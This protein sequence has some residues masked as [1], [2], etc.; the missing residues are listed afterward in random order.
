MNKKTKKSKAATKNSMGIHSIGVQLI[1]QLAVLLLFVCGILIF[2]SYSKSRG[3]IRQ[4]TEE[5]LQSRVKENAELLTDHLNEKKTQIETL[6]RR[7]SIFGM[8]WKE[9]EPVIV[10][11][12][13]RLGYERI[14]VSDANGD[15][16]LPG[17]DV[18]NI[19]DKQNFQISLKGDSYTTTPLFSESDQKLIM[20][21]TAAIRNN[22][23]E[24]VGVLGGVST[25]EDF[26]A[27]VQKIEAGKNG[28]A[29]L[30]DETGKRIAD[31]DIQKVQDGQNDVETYA[32]NAEYKKYIDV[33]KAMM[34]GKTGVSEYFYEGENYICAYTPVEGTTWSLAM[35]YQE[36]EALQDLQSLRNFMIG[37]MIFAMILG[38]VVAVFI[39]NRIRKPLLQMQKFAKELA[40]GNLGYQIKITRKDEFGETCEHLN[41]AAENMKDSMLIIVDNAS[42]VSAS[43]EELYAT[44]EEITS[45]IEEID[46][47]TKEVVSGSKENLDSVQNVNTYMQKINDNIQ[48]LEEKASSQSEHSAECRKKA[49]VVQEEAQ[50]AIRES[51][52]IYEEQERKIRNSI[53]AGKVVEEI[54]TMANVIADISSEINLLSLNAS[55]EAARAGEMGKGFAVVADQVG[56]LAEETGKSIDSIQTTIEKVQSAF[57]ELSENG[58]ALLNFIDERIKPQM[59]QYQETGQ[60]YYEDSDQMDAM[61]QMILNMVSEIRQ[62][63]TEANTA[64]SHVE[65]TTNDSLEKTTEIQGNISGCTSAMVDVSATSENLAQL[66]EELNTA[67]QKFHL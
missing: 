16:H 3:I 19:G 26:N 53:E 18:F 1:I 37:I 35:V 5:S 22:Q 55:I 61:S 66:A 2:F 11:E 36:K 43:G 34:A 58:Q 31:R 45:R 28:Y 21:T 39:A 24:I 7:E 32:N 38:T 27:I 23:D 67:T 41:Q 20:V 64:I 44:T 52:Q 13:E 15:T 48:Q 6:A 25:A 29:Y 56:K 54:R 12:T 40:D 57:A 9:Q 47:S 14:Q 60:N 51:N 50:K 65:L 46:S 63:V 4:N 17:K 49:L 33:Q 42:N 8:D 59:D 30:I 10:S 62:V